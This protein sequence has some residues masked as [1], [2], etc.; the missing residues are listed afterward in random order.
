MPGALLLVVLILAACQT[1]TQRAEPTLTASPR[2]ITT[3][4]LTTIQGTIVDFEAIREYMCDPD[5]NLVTM[6]QRAERVRT[7]LQFTQTQITRLL[8]DVPDSQQLHLPLPT[9]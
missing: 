8:G 4:I 6:C 1:G 7:S 2:L 5:R 9:R 3:Y